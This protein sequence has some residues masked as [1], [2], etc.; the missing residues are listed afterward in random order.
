MGMLLQR[1]YEAIEAARK[2]VSAPSSS[3]QEY[4]FTDG[5]AKI[6]AGAGYAESDYDGGASGSRDRVLKSDVEA[7]LE[8]A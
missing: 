4:T 2:D 3:D 6:L 5:G 7:W 8:G 1:H